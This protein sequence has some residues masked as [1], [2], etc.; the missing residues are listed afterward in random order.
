MPDIIIIIS[1]VSQILSKLKLFHILV[2]VPV[3]S[4]YARLTVFSSY[5]VE[6]QYKEIWYNNIPDITR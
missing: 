1:L 3:D 4:S 6:T 2:H 5:T